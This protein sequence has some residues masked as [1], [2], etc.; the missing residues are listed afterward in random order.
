VLRQQHEALVLDEIGVVLGV[1]RHQRNAV[2]D[3]TRHHPRVVMGSR[4]AA[5]LG[6]A[7]KPSQ[8][9]PHFWVVG[10]EGAPVAP[11]VEASTRGSTRA[12]DL[13]PLGQFSEGDEGQPHSSAGDVLVNQ[14]WGSV[15][16][17]NRSDIS[18][19]DD[20]HHGRSGE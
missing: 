4:P 7:G 11:R 6:P 16:L 1:E 17:K 12:A 19:D 9:P 15:L 13:R 3:A 20:V 2:A 18:A 10:H 14:G 8:G 5:T